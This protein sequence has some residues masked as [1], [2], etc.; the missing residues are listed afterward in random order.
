MLVFDR[1]TPDAWHKNPKGFIRVWRTTSKPQAH[2]ERSKSS[3]HFSKRSS[4]G[5]DAFCPPEHI[6]RRGG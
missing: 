2:G 5:G 4:G 3:G 1:W 6:V